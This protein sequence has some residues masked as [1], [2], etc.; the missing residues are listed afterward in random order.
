[1]RVR[2]LRARELGD[3]EWAR[4]R[5]IQ[6]RERALASP[7]FSPGFTRAVGQWRDDSR[8]ALIEE[9][10]RIE[11]FFPYQLWPERVAR[12]IGGP[13]SDNHGLVARAGRC[14]NAKELLR[15]CGLAVY[16][17]DHLPATQRTF[18][19]YVR[20]TRPDFLVDLQRGYE[21]YA[22][23]RRTAGSHLVRKVLAKR[24]KMSAEVGPERFVP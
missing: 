14:W 10:N 11:A 15:A 21:A 4:W 2:V 9:G 24:R 18:A 22:E 3:S 17:F 19:P 13:V 12:P 23:E 20:S 6:E 1:M 16:D 7:Y 8:V 5:E